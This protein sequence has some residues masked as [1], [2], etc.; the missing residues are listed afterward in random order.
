[1]T[2]SLTRR[3]DIYLDEADRHDFL[4]TLAESCQ[5]MGWQVHS[6]CLMANHYHLSIRKLA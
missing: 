6:Y 3:Q 4:K 5:K 1:M 2:R